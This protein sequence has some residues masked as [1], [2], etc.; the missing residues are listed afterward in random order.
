M[1]PLNCAARRIC[2]GV[3][4]AAVVLCIGGCLPSITLRTGK[5]IVE[6]NVLAM[7]PGTTTKS[8]LFERLGAPTAIVAR[9]EVPVVAAPP[10]WA[11]PYRSAS[12]YSFDAN[13]FYELFPAAGES[14]E[15]SRIYY[16]RHV[17]SRKMSYFMI[18]AVYES[19]GTTTDRLWVLV[20][21]KTGIVEDYAFRK[22]GATTVFGVPR[23][24]IPR[25]PGR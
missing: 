21:E 23:R 20:N 2:R 17:A 3:A 15:Y 18:L 12:T 7:T 13:T 5:P 19:G 22:S 16:Y 6:D 8:E 25:P 4:A 11:A 14:G 1:A 9:D 10:T 24:P